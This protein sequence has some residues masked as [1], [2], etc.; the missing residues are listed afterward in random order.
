MSKSPEHTKG[1]NMKTIFVK[2][3]EQKRDWYIVD[4]SG[5]T[6][7]RVAAKVASVLRGKHKATFAPSQNMGDYV[8]IINAGKIVVSG[9]KEEKKIYYQYT[10][11]VGNLKHYSFESLLARHPEEPLMIA[12]KGMLPHN[13]LGRAL[14]GNVKIYADE[15]HPHLAQNPKPLEV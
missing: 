8:V 10:G 12:I 11:Y 14:L 4:A 6:L 7:G 15:K 5:K 2:E 9:G 3:N 1:K 13:R